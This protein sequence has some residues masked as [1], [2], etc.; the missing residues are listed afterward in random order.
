MADLVLLKLGVLPK[1]GELDHRKADDRKR[2]PE[3]I[4][5]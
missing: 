5:A 2:E 3:G 1:M 4:A